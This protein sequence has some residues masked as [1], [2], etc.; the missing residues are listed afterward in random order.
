MPIYDYKCVECND[1]IEITHS[2]S[3]TINRKCSK[4]KKGKLEKQFSPITFKLHGE[5]FYKQ[6]V[7]GKN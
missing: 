1:T 6:G 4:C 5:G 2:I 7:S 3:K